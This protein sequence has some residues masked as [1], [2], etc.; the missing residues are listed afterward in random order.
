MYARLLTPQVW[1]IEKPLDA[2]GRKPDV[3]IYSLTLH[4]GSVARHL[5]KKRFRMKDGTIEIREAFVLPNGLLVG[6]SEDCVVKAAHG[7]AKPTR[8]VDSRHVT[9]VLGQPVKERNRESRRKAK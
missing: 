5:G 9:N 3:P 6:G 8:P 7:N 4:V 2:N 1:I